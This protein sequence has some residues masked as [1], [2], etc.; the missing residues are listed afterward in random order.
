MTTMLKGTI[1]E[2]LLNTLYVSTAKGVLR[3]LYL[4]IFASVYI[5]S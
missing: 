2:M 4:K 5:Y 1:K 3:V